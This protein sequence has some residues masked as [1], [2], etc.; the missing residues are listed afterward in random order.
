MNLTKENWQSEDRLLDDS[1]R[2]WGM[3]E[4]AEGVKTYAFPTIKQVSWGHVKYGMVTIC[5]IPYLKVAKKV[6]LKS[7]H[8][9]KIEFC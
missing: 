8:H 4:W 3:G 7:Y 5:C 6:H 1:G 9:K 2:E